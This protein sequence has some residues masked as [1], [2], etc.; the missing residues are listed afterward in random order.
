MRVVPCARIVPDSHSANI[1]TGLIVRKSLQRIGIKITRHYEPR[2]GFARMP[3]RKE[4]DT[5][6]PRP[7]YLT[8]SKRQAGGEW[9][10]YPDAASVPFRPET[11]I[12]PAS[13]FNYTAPT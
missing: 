4:H 3:N 2:D 9:M 6:L 11:P 8:H 12:T 1:A 7:H 10:Y 5:V 13:F